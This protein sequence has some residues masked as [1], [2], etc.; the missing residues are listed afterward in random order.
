MYKYIYAKKTT[1]ADLVYYKKPKTV[2]QEHGNFFGII[3]QKG[4]RTSKG[5]TLKEES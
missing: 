4:G 3:A 1:L 5:L 2:I